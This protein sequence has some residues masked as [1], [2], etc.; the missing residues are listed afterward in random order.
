MNIKF[1]L[2]FFIQ[3]KR[4]VEMNSK[5]IAIK[6]IAPKI[7]DPKMIFFDIK[8]LESILFW[9]RHSTREFFSTQPSK[10]FLIH[11]VDDIGP[12]VEEYLFCRAKKMY[13]DAMKKK[14]SLF[15]SLYSSEK[16]I[17]WIISRYINLFVS[18]STNVKYKNYIDIYKLKLSFHD[19]MISNNNDIEDILEFEKLQKLPKEQIIKA[20]KSIWEDGYFDNSLDKEDIEELS[21]KFNLNFKDIFETCELVKLNLEK[22]QIKNGNAQLVLVF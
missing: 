20:L 7:E 13:K 2:V 8:I 9:A 4:G 17:E 5:Q 11:Y 21:K 12:I 18:L 14:N 6:Y 22:V 15:N 3:N 1:D 16:V 19:E 10:M